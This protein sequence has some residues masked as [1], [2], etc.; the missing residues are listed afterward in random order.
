MGVLPKAWW[1]EADIQLWTGAGGAWLGEGSSP[2]LH[3][4]L[5]VGFRAGLET[6]NLGQGAEKGFVA[7]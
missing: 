4:A 6:V 1:L 2:A 3:S 5:E 7:P